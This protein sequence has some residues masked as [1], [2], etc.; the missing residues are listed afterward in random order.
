MISFDNTE[1]AFESKSNSDLN[2]SYWLFNLMGKPWLVKFGKVATNVAFTLHLPVKG[3]IKKTIF[4]QFCGGESIQDCDLKINQLNNYKIGTI[5]DYSVEGKESLADLE[6]T[7]EEIIDTILKGKANDAIP[8]SVFKITGVSRFS[9]LEKANDGVENLNEKEKQEFASV[10]M[11]VDAICKAAFENDVPVFIDAEDS[12]I[13]NSI[14]RMADAMMAKYNKE[15]AC[16]YNTIQ[17]YRH[18]RLDF[19]KTSHQKAKNG[20]YI[21]GVKLVR[22]AY[23]EKERDRA[24]AKGYTSPIQPNKAAT[25][26]DYNLALTYMVEH[27]NNIAVC[28]GTH[29]EESSAKLIALIETH[30]LAKNHPHLYF[31]QLLGMSDHISFNLSFKGYNVAKYVPYGPIQEVM[32]YLIRRAEEN[33]S[34]AG[35]MGRELSLIVK[36]KKRRKAI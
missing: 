7:K 28:A 16:V 31:A 17:M 12:W 13:Q 14:D 33:T 36:E 6:A 35:Q 5:L 32:P 34:V 1:I 3:L 24:K 26:R 4:K 22:G 2:W 20:N 15:K 23:M 25:D 11:R 8:F 19:L 29:N 21:L 9:L 10:L 30:Q 27:I 18:D